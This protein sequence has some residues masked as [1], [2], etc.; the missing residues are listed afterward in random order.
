MS[1][2]TDEKVVR[3]LPPLT[4]RADCEP[5]HS[6]TS[7]AKTARYFVDAG[8]GDD[9]G[10][11]PTLE[12]LCGEDKQTQHVVTRTRIEGPRA[13]RSIQLSLGVRR[14]PGDGT[15]AASHS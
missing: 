9:L 8:D 10:R 2:S 7:S 11:V 4:S 14:H 12:H 1:S 13:G 5:V 15:R 6:F 3:K